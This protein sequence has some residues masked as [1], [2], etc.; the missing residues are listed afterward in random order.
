MLPCSISQFVK[1]T[2]GK[3]LDDSGE[4]QHAVASVL[5]ALN[6]EAD[7]QQELVQKDVADYLAHM[8]TAAN[9]CGTPFLPC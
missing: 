6:V 4:I 7:E 1:E 2:G 9:L 3:A 8:C 5:Q